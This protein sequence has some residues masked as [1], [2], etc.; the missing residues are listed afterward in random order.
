MQPRRRLSEALLLLTSVLPAVAAQA[1]GGAPAN[2]EPGDAP[3]VVT[4]GEQNAL[5]AAA[6]KA[7]NEGRYSD[8]ADAFLKLSRSA[9]ERID[10]A[11]TASRR[12]IRRQDITFPPTP[13]GTS[14]S[15]APAPGPVHRGAPRSCC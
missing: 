14:A 4:Q 12:G 6:F 11:S 9:P 1:P 7:E 10:W 3:V 5:R 15:R 2:R 8:A 13:S